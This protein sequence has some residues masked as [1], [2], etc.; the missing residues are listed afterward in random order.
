MD[1]EKE[2]GLQ[3]E[4]EDK[5]HRNQKYLAHYYKREISTFTQRY[6][7][8]ELFREVVCIVQDSED[9][10][11]QSMLP[12]TV[13]NTMQRGEI[14]MSDVFRLLNDPEHASFRRNVWKT[15]G[16]PQDL[17]LPPFDPRTM[18]YVQLSEMIR[19]SPGKYVFLHSYAD[20]REIIFF[21]EVAKRFEKKVDYFDPV[22]AFAGERILKADDFFPH[23]RT[24]FEP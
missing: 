23:N 20:D 17:V 3:N 9:H 14:S 19:C 1:M 6:V 24:N 13:L 18:M 16:L 2:L 4:M 12:K 8:E 15:I 11:L 21:S 7:L 5:M 10:A 22:S